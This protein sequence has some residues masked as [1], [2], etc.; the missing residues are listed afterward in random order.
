[1]LINVT[2]NIDKLVIQF[3]GGMGEL[4]SYLFKGENGYTVVDTGV[5]SEQAIETWKQFL[6]SGITIEKV[7]L[8]HTHQDHIGLAKWFQE[9]IHVPVIVSKSGYEEMKLNCRP[10]LEEEFKALLLAHGAPGI[11]EKMRNQSFIYDFEPDG[12]FENH[13]QIKLGNDTYET[14]WTP[15]HAPDHFCFYNREKKLMVIGDHVLKDISPVIGLWNGKEDNPLREYFPSLAIMHDYPTDIALPGHGELIYH[16]SDRA[17]EL[18]IRHQQRLAQVLELV[19]NE[20]KTAYEVCMEFYGTLN[21]IIY[22]SPF[23]S[24]LTR[25]IYL[26]SIGKVHREEVNGKF[27]FRANKVVVEA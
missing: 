3:P 17:R 7:V 26:E 19:Q 6:A 27:L 15:G 14:I 16:L 24:C 21:I 10:Q 22:L 12:F 9:Q 1:M 2:E 18:E 5:Y 20:G 23:M 11:P 8:T 4:N 13:E 25:L